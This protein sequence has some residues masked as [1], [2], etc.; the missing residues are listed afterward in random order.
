MV[1]GHRSLLLL[2]AAT[3]VLTVFAAVATAEDAKPT[4]LTPV[5]QTPV[6]SFEGDKPGSDD[7]MDDEDAAPVG[8]PIGTTMTEPKPEGSAAAE[9]ATPTA[10]TAS[11]LVAMASCGVAT[12]VAAAGVFAF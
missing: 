3:A 2:L 10:S 4:I 1:A 7:A 9:G 8:S 5:A 6:G 11:S 12:M